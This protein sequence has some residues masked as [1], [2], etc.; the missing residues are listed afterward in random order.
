[1]NKL[2]VLTLL[3]LA[4]AAALRAAGKRVVFIAPP[5]IASFDIGVCRER[6]R[7][8]RIALGA[9]PRCEI[10]AVEYRQRRH[11]VIAL[12]DAVQTAGL[13]VISFDAVLCAQG[14][15]RTMLNETPL[16]HAAWDH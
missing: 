1:M 7:T 2:L 10:D 9:S 11:E 5:P 16:G 6:Q 4:T 14:V 3:L 12:L 8:G 13:P 15:C